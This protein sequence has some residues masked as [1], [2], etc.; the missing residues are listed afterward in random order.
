MASYA[1]FDAEYYAAT[2]PDVAARWTGP[3]LDHYLQWGYREERAPTAWFDATYYRASNPDLQNMSGAQLFAHY[4]SYGY[5][6]GRLPSSEFEGF[7]AARYLADYPDLVPGG[8]TLNTALAHYLN[9]GQEEQRLAYY[10]DGG[11]ITAGNPATGQDLDLTQVQD[12]ITGGAGNDTINGVM[13]APGYLGGGGV[14]SDNTL[15]SFD[16]INGAGGVDTL[17]VTVEPVGG[18]YGGYGGEDNS[19]HLQ[20][21]NVE[22]MVV[23]DY[24]DNYY[25]GYNSTTFYLEN[26]NGLNS[27]SLEASNGEDQLNLYD[28]NNVVANL[29]FHDVTGTI[30]QEAGNVAVIDTLSVTVE[31]SDATVHVYSDSNNTGNY[32]NLAVNSIG[33][34]PNADIQNSLWAGENTAMAS[35][36]VTGDTDLDLSIEHWDAVKTID[37]SKLAAGLTMDVYFQQAGASVIGGSGDDLIYTDSAVAVTITTGDGN[38]EVDADEDGSTVTVDTGK[39]NDY[40]EA[41][42]SDITSIM[43]GE[44]DD[45]VYA[46]GETEATGAIAAAAVINLGAGNDV[47]DLDYAPTPGATLA[48]G[49]GTDTLVLYS[50]DWTTISTTFT[51][52]DL[53]KITGFEVL[54]IYDTLPGASEYDLSLLPGL[55]SFV[56]DDGVATGTTAT[57]SNVLSGSSV[58]LAGD[59]VANNGTLE[60]LVK[61]AAAATADVLNLTVAGDASATAQITAADVETLNVTVSDSSAS[62]NSYVLSLA[63]D[64]LKSLTIAGSDMATFLAP[65]T[66]TALT[67]I[68]AS[69][70]TAGVT[71]SVQGTGTA[72]TIMGTVAADTVSVD[73]NDVV[74]GNGGN[75]TFGVGTPTSGQTYSTVTDANKGDVIDFSAAAGAFTATKVTL[76]PTAVFQDYLDA[77][78]AGNATSNV[79]WFTWAGDTYVAQDNSAALTFQNGSDSVVKLTGLVDLTLATDVGGNIVIG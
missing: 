11:L 20:M 52:P 34:T 12:N 63:D 14:T 69:A 67:S 41:A 29:E 24:N 19:V 8:V 66:N 42:G 65:A 72:V 77:V 26:T 45:Y 7:D 51:A 70:N 33:Q 40:V 61:G 39:G 46:F 28:G 5:K 22:Q 36:S 13:Q 4:N 9:F 58:T 23:R 53:A 37:A 75:D 21:Q 47:L 6:E 30:Y 10:D 2:N 50:A 18:Y 15:Q 48:G 35:I 32:K 68:N 49:D 60:V 78:V 64:A 54:E 73:S 17:V 25:Y 56:A 43:T 3:L 57:V 44:G 31:N 1:M 38:D 27:V 62:V 59:L 55:N 16:T 74:T 71:L 79:G 76:A